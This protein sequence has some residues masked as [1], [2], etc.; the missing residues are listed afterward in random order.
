MESIT[1]SAPAKV[2]LMLKVLGRRAD[3]YHDIL[4]LFE[5]ISLSDTVTITKTR[6]GIDIVSDRPI[7]ARPEDNIAY[8]A[9]AAAL[10]YAGSDKGVKIEIK[11]RIP[12]AAGL[13]GGSSDAAAV[14]SG[15]NRLFSLNMDN[16]A[17]RR[18]GAGLGADVPFF[19]LGRPFALGRGIGER[20]RVVMPRFKLWHL[21]IYPGFKVA[22]KGVYEAFDSLKPK[23][24]TMKNTGVRINSLKHW[25]DMEPL[26]CNDLEEIAAGRIPVIGKIIKCLASSLGKKAIVSGSGPSVFCLYRTGKEA[27]KAKDRLFRCV[28]EAARRRWQV[29]VVGTEV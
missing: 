4:T 6:G 10:G 11:K 3:G 1:L 12:I 20:L 19:L 15:I 8:K 16:R 17:L 18:L 2:N 21:I 24:L 29:F 5:R 23:C 7:T 13:G 28:P 14:L 27:R 22:T 26:L 25:G 9:A